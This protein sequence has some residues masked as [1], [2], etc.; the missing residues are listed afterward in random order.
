MGGKE[1]KERRRLQRLEAQKGPSGDSSHVQWTP[2]QKAEAAAARGDIKPTTI[3]NN[4]PDNRRGKSGDLKASSRK[5]HGKPNAPHKATAKVSA[6][7]V[8]QG[9]G[10]KP[11]GNKLNLG[12]S[13]KAA[14]VNTEKKFKKPK[15]LKRKLEHVEKDDLNREKLVQELRQLE[16]RKKAFS[17]AAPTIQ[18]P[19]KP[20][21]SSHPKT[22]ELS[23]KK[24]KKFMEDIPDV[25]AG[26]YH[27]APMAKPTSDSK[28]TLK[29]DPKNTMLKALKI[30]QVG[31]EVH[32]SFTNTYDEL[33]NNQNSESELVDEKSG[34][35]QSIQP[36]EEMDST[37]VTT[38]R[39][40][41]KSMGA[42]RVVSGDTS[43]SDSDSDVELEEP[44]KRQRGRGRKRPDTADEVKTKEEGEKKETRVVVTV[45]N[46]GKDAPKNEPAKK[47]KKTDDKRRCVG[48]KPVTDYSV[49][50]RYTGKV[51]Y[52]KPFGVFIDIG[53]HSDAFCHVSRLQDGF[54]DSSEVAVKEGDEVNARVVE[55]DRKQ[56][57][58]TVS[59]QT[60]A[61]IEDEKASVLA[62]KARDEKRA[63]SKK[64]KEKKNGGFDRSANPM[65]EEAVEET[66]DATNDLVDAE[67]NFLKDESQMAPAEVKRARKLQRRAQRRT[68]KEETGI[69]A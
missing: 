48:R 4:Y 69:S 19:Q 17:K 46:Q 2:Q 25:E 10:K 15:H 44:L 49:G 39:S 34:D 59:L 53:C 51:V 22:K 7:Y 32:D 60:D 27:S 16:E 43:D 68:Q 21:K 18:K 3:S 13:G 36:V 47:T 33:N 37:N 12:A 52:I 64:M 28:H 31:N 35:E 42:V 63:N 58:V 29:T 57:R 66:Q 55:V 67:G 30:L 24:Q 23:A 5:A 1:A 41:S 6:K 20:I 9:S 62:R 26:I 50:Q 38:I 56:K 61:R 11:F 40:P 54:V 14:P 65:I 45:E 8:L